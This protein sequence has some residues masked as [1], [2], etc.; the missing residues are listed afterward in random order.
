MTFHKQHI[1]S[2]LNQKKFSAAYPVKAV[3]DSNIYLSNLLLRGPYL[4][5]M[6]KHV[7]NLNRITEIQDSL[8]FEDALNPNVTVGWYR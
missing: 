8:P 1:G 7:L 3:T 6:L 2:S 5:R 4:P